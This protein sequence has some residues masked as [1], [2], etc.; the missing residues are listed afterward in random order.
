M[1]KRHLLTLADRQLLDR[2]EREAP[3]QAERA[4]RRRLFDSD[5]SDYGGSDTRAS[6]AMEAL[7]KPFIGNDAE[8]LDR[9]VVLCVWGV[10]RDWDNE[11]FAPQLA[12]LESRALAP[13]C[14]MP[15]QTSVQPA[16]TQVTRVVPTQPT[17]AG[18][19]VS[20]GLA[21]PP[22]PIVRQP[23]TAAAVEFLRATLAAGE[24]ESR[25]LQA[26]ARSLRLTPAMIRAARQRLD[27]ASEKRGFGPLCRSWWRLPLV[28]TGVQCSQ[29]Q[30]AR[31]STSQDGSTGQESTT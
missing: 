25:A 2:L 20:A 31:P 28:M 26:E 1:S 23:C 3:D 21:Q 12:L 14:P 29:D 4:K 5:L 10:M 6:V 30:S 13:A 19:A 27:V 22:A 16:A 18:N 15:S 7:L 17:V 8:R 24:R 11:Y 9:I